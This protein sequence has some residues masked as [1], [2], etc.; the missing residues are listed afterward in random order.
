MLTHLVL[1]TVPEGTAD[2]RIDALVDGLRAL[3]D[4]VEAIDTYRVERDLGL[5]DGNATVA[6]QATFASPEAL[7]TYIDHPAHQ[8]VVTD[9]IR[10]IGATTVRAQVAAPS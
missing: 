4:Q 6:I 7:R 10:A 3:P 2:D 5:A 8:A 9:L 1:I